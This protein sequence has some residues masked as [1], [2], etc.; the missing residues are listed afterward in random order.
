MGVNLF[1]Y[2]TQSHIV[3]N[4]FGSF[5]TYSYLCSPLGNTVFLWTHVLEGSC[6]KG[7]NRY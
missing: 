4:T 6:W 1:Q 7:K 2:K 3:T 5:L